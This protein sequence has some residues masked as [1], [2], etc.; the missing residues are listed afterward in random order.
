[1]GEDHTH[2]GV[3]LQ[4]AVVQQVHDGPG[5]VEDVLHDGVRSLQ[6]RVFW[7]LAVRGMDEHHRLAAAELGKHL[8]EHRIAE[9]TATLVREQAD[10]VQAQHIERVGHLLQRAIDVRQRQRGE[11]AE[12][13][14]VVAHEARLKF[15]A[16][17][18][19]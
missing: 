2:A 15:I 12:A 7:R 14:R 11:P 4:C 9:V 19:D 5:G 3:A 17:S 10:T 13:L 6:V 18:H 8:V 16:G 1:M